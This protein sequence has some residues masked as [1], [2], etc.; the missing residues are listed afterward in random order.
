MPSSRNFLLKPK[1]LQGQLGEHKHR[2]LIDQ[3]TKSPIH[4]LLYM[5]EHTDL[6]L[7]EYH[8]DESKF[9]TKVVVLSADRVRITIHSNMKI[10]QELPSE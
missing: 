6:S 9:I 1:E 5:L 3:N 8:D 4:E 2:A 7:K 10:E